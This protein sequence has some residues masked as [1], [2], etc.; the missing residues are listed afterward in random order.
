MRVLGGGALA[1]MLLGGTAPVATLD[2]DVTSLRNAKGMIRV[3]LT[4]DPDNFP[5]CIDDANAKTRSVAANVRTISFT[6]L[7][8]GHYAVAVIHDE[9]SNAKLDTFAG[10]PREG[11]G[12]SR[13][14]T[15]TFGPP[16]FTAAQFAIDSDADRQQVRM[17][18]IF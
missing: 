3:C 10:I 7:P 6:G 13:N 12:F 2:V 9:N 8:H 18:Y 16:R 17:R 15:I 11:F 5:A 1:A 4:A 14:P